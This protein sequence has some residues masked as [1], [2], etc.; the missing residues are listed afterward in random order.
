MEISDLSTTIDSQRHAIETRNTQI[1]EL[2]AQLEQ[3]KNQLKLKG[4]AL[5]WSQSKSPQ[6]QVS[7]RDSVIKDCDCG[8]HC[9]SEVSKLIVKSD[10]IS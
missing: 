5:K 2:Q 4:Q 1:E 6:Q 7:T 3:A 10:G 8:E 9:L